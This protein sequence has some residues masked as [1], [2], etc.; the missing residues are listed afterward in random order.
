[1]QINDLYKKIEEI[2]GALALAVSGSRTSGNNDSKSDYDLYV[3][4]D[5]FIPPEIREEYLKP[6]CSRA[7]FGNFYFE[8]ED[9]IVLKDGTPVDIIYR[10]FDY[11]DEKMRG[12]LE[13]YYTTNGY[14]TCFWHNIKFSQII[15]DKTGDLSGLVSRLQCPYPEELKK[16]IIKRNMA[17]LNGHL[18][19]YD[20]QVKKA[21]ERGDL[22]SV[23]HRVA[24]FLESYFDVLFALNEL[25]HP[26]EKRLVEICRRDCKILPENFESNLE[27]L[28]KNMFERDVSDILEDIVTELKKVV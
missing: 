20:K 10:D 24:A 14:T 7:E 16:A 13:K 12:L 11:F 25:T 28:F 26:G 1:M 4:F 3:Y 6:L 8:P 27:R 21:F 5:T 15:F 18:P 23:N 19:S 9:N 22:V 2:P 17:L